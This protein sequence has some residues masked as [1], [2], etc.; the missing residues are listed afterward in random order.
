MTENILTVI[1]AILWSI[2]PASAFGAAVG[3]IILINTI[4]DRFED[5]KYTFGLTSAIIGYFIAFPF[6]NTSYEF[7]IALLSSSTV[8]FIIIAFQEMIN[9]GKGL[10]T[11]VLQVIQA[12]GESINIIRGKK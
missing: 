6:M 2:S 8:L 12:I 5:K 9:K 3:A 10:P 11:W 1:L 4:E 7:L